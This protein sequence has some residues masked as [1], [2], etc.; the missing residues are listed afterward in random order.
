[1]TRSTVPPLDLLAKGHIIHICAKLNFM[2]EDDFTWFSKRA[3][4]TERAKGRGQ[5]NSA[6]GMYC[7]LCGA[8]CSARVLTCVV[9]VQY[10][11]SVV[12]HC[13][14]TPSFVPDL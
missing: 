9:T 11:H 14:V 5:N 2:L 1:M 13:F 12:D 3:P 4:E 6:A 7:A 10:G 8:K